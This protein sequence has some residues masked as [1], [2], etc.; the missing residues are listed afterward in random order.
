MKIYYINLGGNLVSVKAKTKKQIC[1]HF[2]ISLHELNYNCDVSELNEWKNKDIDY[3][4]TITNEDIIMFKK[5]TRDT[6]YNKSHTE[7]YIGFHH[8]VSGKEDSVLINFMEHIPSFQRNNDKWTNKMQI[9]YVENVLKGLNNPILIY[10][11]QDNSKRFILDGLQR[12][13]ALNLFINN[14]LKVFEKYN[15]IDILHK[16][17][18]LA[19]INVKQYK[20]NTEIEAVEFYIL[21]NE[22]I[23]HS[24]A[25]I[26][27][28]KDYL[29]QL[30]C[31]KGA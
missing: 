18:A 15:Y 4:L 26:Q 10:T 25:D 6:A 19:R 7:S 29:V 20:F 31:S 12:I 23:T 21:M 11:L 22:N 27:R 14:E 24:K 8:G 1:E 30:L 2:S 5:L 9:S 3:N 28:A 13:T 17:D 16:I